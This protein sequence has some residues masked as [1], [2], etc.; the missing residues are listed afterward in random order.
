MMEDG[1]VSVV[2]DSKGGFEM[3]DGIRVMLQVM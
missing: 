1:G 3:W 2:D